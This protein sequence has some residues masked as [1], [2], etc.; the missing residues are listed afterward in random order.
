MHVDETGRGNGPTVVLLNVLPCRLLAV[1]G[2][3]EHE[4]ILRSLPRLADGFAHG[5]ARTAPGV[6]HAWVGQAPDLFSAMVRAHVADTALPDELS[7]V[8]GA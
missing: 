2:G 4:L 5:A 6:G 1:A 8:A 3:Q 7:R